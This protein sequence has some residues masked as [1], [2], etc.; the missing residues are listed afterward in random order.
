MRRGGQI[1]LMIILLVLLSGCNGSHETDQLAYVVAIGVDREENG[2]FLVTYQIAVPREIAGGGDSGSGESDSSGGKK[3]FINISLVGASFAETR[4]ELKSAISLVPVMYQAKM[5][6]L[7]EDL[8]RKGVGDV[9]AP[10]ARFRE[11]RGSMYV[12]VAAGRAKEFLEHNKP[13]ISTSSNKYYELMMQSDQVAGSFLATSLHAFYHHVKQPGEDAYVTF[14]GVNPQAKSEKIEKNPAANQTRGKHKMETPQVAGNIERS[15]GNEAEFMGVAV[16][17]GDRMTGVLDSHQTRI[18][19]MLLRRFKNGFI[20]VED[21]LITQGK[22]GINLHYVVSEPPDVKVGFADG[23]PIVQVN[24]KLEGEITSIASGIHYED[25]EKRHQLEAYM[26]NLFTEDLLDFFQTTQAMNSDV[27][28]VGN[29]YRS[30]FSLLSAYRD[31]D[32]KNRY[33]LAQISGNV[34][35]KIRRTGLMWQT[36]PIEE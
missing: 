12:T 25:I 17:H 28:G 24:L 7:G 29:Y 18:L 22:K 31:F 33:S 23:K 8:A 14:V 34:E 19:S 21:P 4:N 36:K 6:I 11:F 10:L 32:W 1:L 15:G 16:F 9:L 27:F 20:S 3:S 13:S 26:S 2:R 5:I 35:F 30:Q